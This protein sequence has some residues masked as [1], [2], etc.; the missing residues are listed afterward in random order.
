[1]IAMAAGSLAGH[2]LECGAQATGGIHTDW[3]LS[4]DWDNIGFPIAEVSP[5]GS[6]RQFRNPMA[7]AAW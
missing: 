2:I 3:H 1:M 4:K 6:I 7:P 5:D